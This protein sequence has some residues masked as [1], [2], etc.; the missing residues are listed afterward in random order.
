M[1]WFISQKSMKKNRFV[2]VKLWQNY[3]MLRNSMH[4]MDYFRSILNI[5]SI[6]NKYC[7]DSIGEKYIYIFFWNHSPNIF[8]CIKGKRHARNKFHYLT[9]LLE[10]SFFFL[11]LQIYFHFLFFDS[12]ELHDFVT[13]MLNFHTMNYYVI[14]ALYY[15]F[16]MKELCKYL[17]YYYIH[18]VCMSCFL[19]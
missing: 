5:T 4:S 9:Q 16:F 10:I 18:I 13:L 2:T 17:G 1:L 19:L 8:L 14:D 3:A 12:F 6:F 15:V 11:L 7:I